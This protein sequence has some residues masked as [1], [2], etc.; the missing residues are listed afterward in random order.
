MSTVDN[1]IIIAEGLSYQIVKVIENHKNHYLVNFLDDNSRKKIKLNQEIY[2]LDKNIEIVK[3]RAK[4][5]E[6][7]CQVDTQLISE[8]L[9]EGIK[10]T[11]DE[12]AQLYYGDSVDTI[13]K[14][15]L[16]LKLAEDNIVF[17]NYQNGTFSKCNVEEQQQRRQILQKQQFAKEQYNHYLHLFQ[18]A[19]N[20]LSKINAPEIDAFKLLHK[21]D[22][23]SPSYKALHHL[24]VEQKITPLEF[25]H[26]IGL[27]T[28]LD[29]FF[30][31]CFI[32]DNFPN[33]NLH[34]L[35]IIK[36]NT[37]DLTKRL[38]L[39]VFS[40]DD[41]RTTEIDD[42]F[43]V[44]IIPDGYKIGIHIAA[45]ALSSELDQLVSDN[46]STVYFPG[47]KITMLPEN[48]ISQFSLWENKTAPAVS[49][50]FTI[51]NEFEI[52]EYDTSI[53]LVK[54]SANLRI[55]SLETLFNHEN[56]NTNNSYLYENELKVLYKFAEKLEE[57]R[58]KP[59]VNNLIHDYNFSFE[60][61]K[62]IIKPRI[63]GNPIDKLVS[64]L[65]I[66]ANCSWGRL[67]TNSFIPAIYR[68]KQPNYPV[69]MTLTPDSHTG[70]NV[71]YYTWSTSPLRRASDYINQKQ[72][73]SMIKHSK[74]F[75]TGLDPILLNV[76]NNFDTKY[77]KY[78]DFQ[79]KMEKFW[80]LKYLLQENITEIDATITYKSNAQIE[81]VPL[82]IDLSNLLT[83]KQRGT[84]LRLKIYNINPANVSFDFKI[85]T[86]HIA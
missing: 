72:I 55:E 30:I 26:K 54:I 11:L 17:H 50:F 47:N 70:L 65:M 67:L 60:D 40:I 38:D 27:V 3:F 78:I 23:H 7:K 35:E 49:I 66:L 74:D 8:L 34:E 71:D 59:S 83:P 61:D 51:N 64:E 41:S 32:K 81:G 21:P 82:S 12:M 69:K 39:N 31:Q 42:A 36:V 20:E 1:Y 56:L 86:P 10:T 33:D 24:S 58:G 80:S 28:N 62:I 22:K 13:K 19:Y 48:I 14:T 73:I 77:A 6:E 15:A 29:A 9:E 18:N 68:V 46:I 84:K 75:Y 53:N 43:S 5:M 45:P 63:R 37:D 16:L 79:N 4:V 25:C 2:Q 85:I 52:I 57:K 44:E 76:V